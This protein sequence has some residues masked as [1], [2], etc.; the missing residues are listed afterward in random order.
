[1][2]SRLNILAREPHRCS[3]GIWP[4][5]ALLALCALSSFGQQIT[6]N[7][8]QFSGPTQY[9]N[10]QAAPFL[11]TMGATFT[12]G[13]ILTHETN[14]VV[15]GTVYGAAQICLGCGTA[16]GIDFATPVSSFSMLLINGLPSTVTYAIIDDFGTTDVTLTSFAT[17]L[18]SLPDKKITHVS[19][20]AST[21]GTVEWDFSITN[22]K[23]TPAPAAL[24]DPV[25]ALITKSGITQNTA[26]LCAGG[27]IVKNVVSDG[28]T[29]ALVRIQASTVGEQFS[30]TLY[31]DLNVVSS[32]PAQDGTLALLGSPPTALPIVT[33]VSTP[34]G[35]MAF[36]VYTAPK[37]FA[38]TNADN[39]LGKRDGY[40]YVQSL[41][42][43]T[44]FYVVNIGIVRP[45]VFLIHGLWDSDAG[46][47]N[48]ATLTSDSRFY[49]GKAN[50][51]GPLPS[52]SAVSPSSLTFAGN[53]PGASS[54]GVAYSAPTVLKQLNDFID[55]FKFA[56]Q[57]AA[58]Q[59]DIIAHSMGGLMT[60]GLRQVTTFTGPYNYQAGPIHK[61]IT[62]GTPHLGS[63]LALQLLSGNNNC[64][65]GLLSFAGMWPIDTVVF[66]LGSGTKYT[67]AVNDLQGDGTGGEL[68]AFLKSTQTTPAI[69]FP[70]AMIAGTYNAANFAGL[71]SLQKSTIAGFG[72]AI[73]PHDT[74]TINYLLTANWAGLMGSPS[75]DGIV[76]LT[77]ELNNTPPVNNA[78]V[79]NG[80]VHSG[81]A[82]A[83]GFIGPTEL[84]GAAGSAIQAIL[85]LNEWLTGSDYHPM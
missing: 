16:I 84:D 48:Y 78:L 11:N 13:A 62:I 64:L 3:P 37:D 69:Q 43:Q 74:I 60:K 59:A 26:F 63:P 41:A 71:I 8:S 79:I 58:V 46:W 30:L 65:V 56:N 67:G 18:V 66:S 82:E 61:V 57:A 49:T 19:I 31:N 75:S 6:I 72:A 38:R 32:N 10:T 76:P 77:S 55:N 52:I 51:G 83:I 7:F 45:P 1:M 21:L 68:S 85:L 81:G 42:N 14:I 23:F 70:T 80:I 53:Y 34:N 54:V 36:G 39:S 40:I 47:S 17:Q 15:G 50:W 2:F 4:V 25:P 9:A 35:P 44:S 29:Q 22:V 33:A 24:V 27:T 20:Q 12:G 28:V 5:S 73:C